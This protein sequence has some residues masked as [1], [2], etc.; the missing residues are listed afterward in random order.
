[1]F[2]AAFFPKT[3]KSNILKGVAHPYEVGGQCGIIWYHLFLDHCM[4]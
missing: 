4:C 3:L 2:P 1:M